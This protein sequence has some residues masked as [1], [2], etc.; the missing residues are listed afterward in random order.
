MTT[1]LE[2]TQQSNA[3]IKSVQFPSGTLPPG[4]SASTIVTVQNTGITTHTF[5]IGVSY[6]KPDGSV[7]DLPPSSLYLSPGDTKA[8]TVGPWSLP[9]NAPGGSYGGIAAVWDGYDSASN[10][11]VA[12]KYDEISQTDIFTVPS[13]SQSSSEVDEPLSAAYGWNGVG[14]SNIFGCMSDAMLNGG[15]VRFVRDALGDYSINVDAT[16]V[17]NFPEQTDW[18]SHTYTYV[19]EL[20]KKGLFDLWPVDKEEFQVQPIDRGA[21]PKDGCPLIPFSPECVSLP[22]L[23]QELTFRVS[24]TGSYYVKVRVLDIGGWLGTMTF[25]R[26]DWSQS[27]TASLIIQ[28]LSVQPVVVAVQGAKQNAFKIAESPSWMKLRPFSGGC[29]EPNSTKS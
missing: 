16:F 26:T 15:Q 17:G 11:M 12:P 25:F 27:E 19:V 28:P 1:T 9:M 20:H 5:W 24:S 7:Y 8:M 13:A 23:S 21:P 18:A 22:S 6:V 29:Q 2:Q 14:C 10:L 3:K 4:S